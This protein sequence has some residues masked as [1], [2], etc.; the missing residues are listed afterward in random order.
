MARH[1]FSK[2]WLLPTYALGGSAPASTPAMPVWSLAVNDSSC[3]SSAVDFQIQKE[4]LLVVV[5]VVGVV[6]VGRCC[7]RRRRCN[8]DVGKLSFDPLWQNMMCHT[9]F[10]F[11]AKRSWFHTY[12]RLFKTDN[13]FLPFC[14]GA[15]GCIHELQI[16]RHCANAIGEYWHTWVYVHVYNLCT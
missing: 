5:V 15:K 1:L 13:M 14:V 12:C 10:I 16:S 11:S 3:D 9:E 2:L 4:D 6:V 7:G 8:C